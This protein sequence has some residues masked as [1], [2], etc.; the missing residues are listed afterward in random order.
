MRCRR[1]I[2]R[3]SAGQRGASAPNGVASGEPL[4]GHNRAVI[5]AMTPHSPEPTRK[6]GPFATPAPKP[7][8]H[9]QKRRGDHANTDQA[10]RQRQ[11]SPPPTPPARHPPP[12]DIDAKR[13][14][15]PAPTPPAANPAAGKCLRSRTNT[16][17][18]KNTGRHQQRQGVPGQGRPVRGSR[19]KKHPA[20][21]PAQPRAIGFAGRAS[22]PQAS[23]SGPGCHRPA[24]ASQRQQNGPR[25]VIDQPARDVEQPRAEVRNLLV[26]LQP[27]LELRHH[28]PTR[29]PRPPFAAGTGRPTPRRS[30]A[31][32]HD[33]GEMRPA[34]KLAQPSGTR[35]HGRRRSRR[36]TRG[37]A[38]PWS[39]A[40][41]PGTGHGSVQ[42]RQ[43][44]T[45]SHAEHVAPPRPQPGTTPMPN[46]SDIQRLDLRQPAFFHEA[47]VREHEHAARSAPPAGVPSQRPSATP[48]KDPAP[49][50]L[51]TLGSARGPFAV[52]AGATAKA[53]AASQLMSGGLLR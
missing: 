50:R 42:V 29:V 25:Q 4:R 37:A 49:A 11:G 1:P 46:S 15:R 28:T 51:R 20:R 44:G 2:G 21:R 24:P 17:A 9:E 22:S 18:S 31:C 40:P 26:D 16:S 43:D 19:P 47:D 48:C 32:Q 39:A 6:S 36:R 8:L 45:P 7:A 41:S 33:A 35:Q 5:S 23:L 14:T 12:R 53:T 38:A 52:R 30:R 3:S 13:R 27:P 34:P 10:H